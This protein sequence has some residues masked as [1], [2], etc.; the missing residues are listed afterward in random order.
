LLAEYLRGRET[1]GSLTYGLRTSREGRINA[2]LRFKE[3][4]REL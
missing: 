1:P 3:G 2:E 4:G